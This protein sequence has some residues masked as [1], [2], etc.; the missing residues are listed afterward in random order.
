MD[1]RKTNERSSM[2]VGDKVAVRK[3]NGDIYEGV[4]MSEKKFLGMK[5][6]LIRHEQDGKRKATWVGHFLV[7]DKKFLDE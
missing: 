6:Y 3:N 5:M 7:F 2:K 1:S 4:I